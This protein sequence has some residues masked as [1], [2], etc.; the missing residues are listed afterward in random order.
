MRIADKMAYEQVNAN[1]GKNRSSMADLQAQASTQKR[2]TKPSDDPLAAARSL[3]HKVDLSNNKQF[4]KSLSYARAFLE[5]TD[6]SLGDLTDALVR[7]K[8]LAIQ[9]A[10][11]ASAGPQTRK[12]VATEI[13][14]LYRQMVQVGNRKLGD[15]FI[16]G[17]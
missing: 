2:V 12:A 10:N 3:G 13:N 11:D 8:E 4:S 7:A 9:Q 6:Q 16:F 1:I 5:Y 14:Q 15:R 17:G